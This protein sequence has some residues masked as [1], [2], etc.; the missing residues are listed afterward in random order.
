[1]SVFF[2]R[3]F[4]VPENWAYVGSW[5]SIALLTMTTLPEIAYPFMY[6]KIEREMESAGDDKKRL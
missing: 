3:Y 1:M 6:K 5:P 2:W 4:N